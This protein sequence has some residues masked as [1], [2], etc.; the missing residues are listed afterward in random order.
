VYILATFPG[1][2]PVTRPAA[3][4]AP[5]PPLLLLLLPLLPPPPPP[6]PLLLLL[7]LLLKPWA[8]PAGGSAELC[9]RLP[10]TSA[11]IGFNAVLVLHVCP[12]PVHR[13]GSVVAGVARSSCTVAA[14]VPT[15]PQELP[16]GAAAAV[17]TL[18][19]VCLCLAVWPG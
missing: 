4:T 2:T 13:E 1:Y 9:C 14:G 6:P 19:R 7:L 3:A 16:T 5:P 18:A 11:S 8:P 12:W 17:L 15:V 10:R